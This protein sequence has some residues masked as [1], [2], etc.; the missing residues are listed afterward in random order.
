MKALVI[1][2]PWI[3][4]I[5]SGQKTW[6][7]RSR[8]TRIRGPIALI[9]AGSGLVVGTAEISDCLP[10]LNE[11]E[12]RAHQQ[13]HRIPESEQASAMANR[14]TTPWV[15][16]KVHALK[17]PVPYQHPSG[18]V[19]WV[20]LIDGIDGLVYDAPAQLKRT[21]AP[22][23]LLFEAKPRATPRSTAE[24]VRQ[25]PSREIHGQW[26]DIPLTQGNI[27]N[28]HFYLRA[29]VS[30]LPKDCIGGNNKSIPG[31]SITVRF[32]GG[33][34]VETDIDGDKMILR[35]R[36]PIGEFFARSGCRS[37]DTLRFTRIADREFLVTRLA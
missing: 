26:A 7:M 4:L 31:R 12:M 1:R 11:A 21:Q 15:L 6:E 9:K 36:A 24:V 23:P 2:S 16:S 13:H 25:A 10:A 22:A 5:L 33:A 17:D 28:K 34:S 20:E 30:L 32:E 8:A 37:G 18:A 14:W 35:R 19:T 29:A 3:E 27:N